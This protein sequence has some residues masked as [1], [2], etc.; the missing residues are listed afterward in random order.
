MSVLIKG[1]EMPQ[2]CGGCK[3]MVDKWCYASEDCN[4]SP[5][6]RH[7]DCPLVDISILCH[8]SNMSLDKFIEQLDTQMDYG[9]YIVRLKY[10][11]SFEDKYTYSTEMLYNGVDDIIWMNDWYEGQQEV[12][13]I[14]YIYVQ[15]LNN[16]LE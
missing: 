8:K 5:D 3:F 7:P 4:Y 2:C 6:R 12:K 15:N 13:V 10:K 14:S 1:M 11:Y 16:I 9:E